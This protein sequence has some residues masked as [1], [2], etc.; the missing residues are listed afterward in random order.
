MLWAQSLFGQDELITGT[1]I[2]NDTG[3][4]LAFV[5]ISYNDSGRGTTTDM[6]GDFSIKSSKNIYRLRFTYVSYKPVSLDFDQNHKKTVSQKGEL[7]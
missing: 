4:P 2:D 5:N 3:K 1:V 7:S 6:N